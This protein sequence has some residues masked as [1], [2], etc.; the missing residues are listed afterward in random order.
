MKIRVFILLG[1]IST[2]AWADPVCTCQDV[3]MGCEV[4]ICGTGRRWIMHQC[5]YYLPSGFGCDN[6]FVDLCTP[7][8]LCL[9]SCTPNCS[10]DVSTCNTTTCMDGCGGQCPGTKDC[11]IPPPPPPP[12]CVPNGICS[13]TTPACGSTGPGLDNC[14]NACSLTGP[15][16]PPPPPP[17]INPCGVGM[18]CGKLLDGETGTI[19]LPGRPIEIRNDHG[20]F[21]KMVHSDENGNYS[22]PLTGSLMFVVPVADRNENVVPAN[23]PVSDTN[24]VA[25]FKMYRVPAHIKV[26]GKFGDF[27]VVTTSTIEGSAPPTVQSAGQISFSSVVDRNNVTNLKV[28]YGVYWLTCWRMTN[29][30]YSKNPSVPAGFLKALESV[31]RSCQMG[32]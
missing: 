10:C 8:P 20:G 19:A 11:S 26:S 27:V 2:V 31:D 4:G 32:G 6:V 9:P 7:D 23:I 1:I 16:C 18:I 21:F 3:Y 15:A 28:P 17:P 29:G 14:G 5:S 12:G 24:P 30:S 25:N 22:I 13:G